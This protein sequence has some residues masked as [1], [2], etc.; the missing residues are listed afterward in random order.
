MS[1]TKKVLF[2]CLGNICRSPIAEAVFVDVVSKQGHT[3]NFEI[4]SAAIG[5][6]HVGR[7]PEHRAQSTMKKHGLAYSNTARQIKKEDFNHYDYIFGM[8]D[9]NIGDLNSRSPTG[10]TAKI[11][12]LGDFDPEG[13]RIIRDPYYDDGS[14]GF[15]KCYEQCVRCCSAFL[16]KVLAKEI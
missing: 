3:A 6:W 14:A 11:L 15:E 10:S 8:D 7:R 12:L 5:S 4:D 13:E 1:E 2:V 9:E 16:T